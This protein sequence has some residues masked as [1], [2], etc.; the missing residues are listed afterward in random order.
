MLQEAKEE[1]LISLKCGRAVATRKGRLLND[2]LIERIVDS[3][4]NGLDLR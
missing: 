2:L 1:S 3:C 4:Q